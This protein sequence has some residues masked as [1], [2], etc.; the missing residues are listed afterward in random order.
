MSSK[1]SYG[2]TFY[3]NRAKEKKNGQCPV[4]MRINI[5]GVRVVL[6]ESS[7]EVQ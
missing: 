4:L 2:L 5:N 3:I 7:Q 1:T 6:N